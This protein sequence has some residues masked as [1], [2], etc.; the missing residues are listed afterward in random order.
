MSYPPY[1]THPTYRPLAAVTD[2]RTLI[3]YDFDN[4]LPNQT[5]LYLHWQTR[6][7]YWSQ[8]VDLAADAPFSLPPSHGLFG[9]S[10][11]HFTIHNPQSTYY[12]PIGQGLVWSGSN[13]SLNSFYNLA[14]QEEIT[15][16]QTFYA[17]RPIL[18]DFGVSVR[19][20]G[21]AD[22]GV[23]WAW[24]T[25]VTADNDIPALG[26]IPTLKWIAGSTNHHPRTLTIDATA[27]P[28]Q[29]IGGMVRPYDVFTNRPL[30]ILD[31]RL[32]NERPWIP[33]PTTT[34]P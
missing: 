12:I 22:D 10:N 9:L 24:R 31:E 27:Y 4:T 20:L 17:I 19:L 15:I 34:L 26:G 3:G 5:R 16:S 32:T 30:A 33:L 2:Q 28:G 7:G 23:T 13:P 18:R 11:S 21:F 6:E 25:P 29:Q 14:P 8:T 1:T